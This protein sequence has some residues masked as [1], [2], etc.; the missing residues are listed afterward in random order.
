MVAVVHQAGGLLRGEP[1]GSRCRHESV[2]AAA[3]NDYHVVP[4]E[5]ASIG[6]EGVDLDRDT[7]QLD[8]ADIERH[9]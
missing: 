8:T 6:E 2:V 9:R 1:F 7:G 3:M 5:R 4:I